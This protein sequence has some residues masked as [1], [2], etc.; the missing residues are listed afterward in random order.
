MWRQLYPKY[1]PFYNW[2][3]QNRGNKLSSSSRTWEKYVQDDENN[4]CFSGMTYA[5]FDAREYF[6]DQAIVSRLK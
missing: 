4:F 2:K 5:L 1:I 3:F 6:S